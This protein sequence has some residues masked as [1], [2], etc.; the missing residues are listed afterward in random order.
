PYAH[1]K[2]IDWQRQRKRIENALSAANQVNV[3]DI[4]ATGVK[5]PEIKDALNQAKL[6]AIASINT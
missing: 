5:G 3:Q 1:N 2:G 4:I 6:S